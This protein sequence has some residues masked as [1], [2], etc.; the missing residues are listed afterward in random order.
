M[1]KR[2]YAFK[3]SFQKS[4][5]L[6]VSGCYDVFPSGEQHFPHAANNRSS[7]SNLRHQIRS[8]S[9][10]QQQQQWQ[11]KRTRAFPYRTHRTSPTAYIPV[12]RYCCALRAH[13][14][15]F[16]TSEGVHSAVLLR[17]PMGPCE[18]ESLC[19]RDGTIS[20]SSSSSSSSSAAAAA[21]SYPSA[22]LR[23]SGIRVPAARSGLGYSLSSRRDFMRV[24][25]RCRCA[26]CRKS[27]RENLCREF[28]H[29]LVSVEQQNQDL[30]PPYPGDGVCVCVCVPVC[31]CVCLW[32]RIVRETVQANG[33][34]KG[35][36]TAGSQRRKKNLSSRIWPCSDE[37]LR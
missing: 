28:L 1:V 20:S 17:Q 11:E 34:G 4:K 22:L 32:I 25:R 8:I 9:T 36:T 15:S 23:A 7:R 37:V 30:P 33:K 12:L 29:Y 14:G 26:C 18:T 5:A 10:V 2:C 24:G 35:N 31:V 19:E 21:S 6:S 3:K 27:T 13:G 16:S